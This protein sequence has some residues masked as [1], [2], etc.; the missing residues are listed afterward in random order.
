MQ[1]AELNNEVN[2]ANR[3]Q[4]RI[5][6]VVETLATM[7]HRAGTVTEVAHDARNM[8]TALALYCDLLSEPG[9]LSE[10]H[11]HYANE[12]RLVAAASR[13]LVE[14]LMLVDLND[15]AIPA[16]FPLSLPQSRLSAGRP[17]Q[18]GSLPDAPIDNLQKELLANRSLLDAIAGLA[19]A[20]NVR[21][22]GGARPVHLSRA[23]LTRVL[24]NLVKNAAE[25]VRGA[26]S[27]DITLRE[28]P[29][30]RGEAATLV[31]IVEDS[32]P[33]ISEELLET[34]FESGYTARKQNAEEAQN[35]GGPVTQNGLGL[36]IVRSLMETAGGTI[37]ADN[38]FE[39]GA[40][41]TIEL[42]IRSA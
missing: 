1:A 18:A 19:I 33:G 5:A 37:R 2:I 29:D 30:A 35:G 40:R 32:G 8:V 28:R 16:A 22:E 42:P 12:L 25:A 39:G 4:R 7:K 26:G 20:V 21:T 9:V 31:L 36:A 17:S 3:S 14:K 41:F 6:A 38:R 13:R 24:V 23:D 15:G 10:S 27:I 34:I 11:M